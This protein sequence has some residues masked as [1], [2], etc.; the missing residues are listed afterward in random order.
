MKTGNPTI[1]VNPMSQLLLEFK[2]G[3]GCNFFC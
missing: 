2:D 1:N 3:K